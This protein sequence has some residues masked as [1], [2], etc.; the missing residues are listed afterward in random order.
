[1]GAAPTHHARQDRLRSTCSVLVLP[2]LRQFPAAF[3]PGSCCHT[4]QRLPAPA[5]TALGPGL[6]QH[7]QE[8]E[9]GA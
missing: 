7:L 8:E 2:R 4:H 5:P 9:G 3:Q 6:P 1:V